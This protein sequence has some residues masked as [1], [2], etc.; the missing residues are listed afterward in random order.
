ML[1]ITDQHLSV[2]LGI[3]DHESI[4]TIA[5]A[6]G[7]SIGHVQTLERELFA[8][9]FIEKKDPTR[10]QAAPWK[11]TDKGKETMRSNGLTIL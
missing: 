8:E 10:R 3:R 6:I 5:T 7:R 4:R 2:M 11:I 1:H 9:G